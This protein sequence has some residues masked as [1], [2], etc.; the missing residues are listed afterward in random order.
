MID[1][2]EYYFIHI[3]LFFTIICILLI[4]LILH[5]GRQILD[6]IFIEY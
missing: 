4:S 2:L 1:D 6:F 5:M 3:L